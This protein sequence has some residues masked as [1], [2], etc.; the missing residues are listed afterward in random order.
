M[1][2]SFAMRETEPKRPISRYQQDENGYFRINDDGHKIY[3]RISFGEPQQ[4]DISVL[5]DNADDP[6]FRRM[7][8][9]FVVGSLRH[10]YRQVIPKEAYR[11]VR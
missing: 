4:L 1:I 8:V 9:A 7:P 5:G 11:V 3:I 2:E 6:E 10:F